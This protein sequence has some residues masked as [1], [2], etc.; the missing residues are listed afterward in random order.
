MQQLSPMMEMLQ[1]YGE[2]IKVLGG[3]P[4]AL[5]RLGV[6]QEGKRGQACP[7]TKIGSNAILDGHGRLGYGW[8]AALCKLVKSLIRTLKEEQVVDQHMHWYRE[9]EGEGG[10]G[11][12]GWEGGYG[13]LR[14]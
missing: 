5:R 6:A 2:Q 13:L 10:G 12:G 4:L 9:G 3:N 14:P 1:V 8:M 7:G 11:V